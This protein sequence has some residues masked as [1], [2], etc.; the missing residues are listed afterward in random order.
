MNK[1]I[2]SLLLMVVLLVTILSGC[3]IV[4]PAAPAE[5]A[6]APS[7]DVVTLEFTQWWEPE[8]PA[9]AFRALMD[10]FEAAN[11]GIKVSN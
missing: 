3:T 1:Q 4:A 5:D 7:G 9:G 10:E 6:A 8:L 11:P 2:V